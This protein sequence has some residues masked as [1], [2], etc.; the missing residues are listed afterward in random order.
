MMR[1][2][3]GIDVGGTFTDAVAFDQASG[4]LWTAKA[5]STPADQSEGFADA[6]LEV[7]KAAGGR[8][9]QVERIVHGTT[10]GTN[11]ILERKGARIG[12]L[13]TAGFEDTLYIGRQKRSEMYD[14]FIEPETPGFLAPRRRVHGIAGRLTPEGGELTPL[15]GAAV[16]AALDR[17]LADGIEALAVS[18]LFAYANPAHE[19]RTLELVRARCPELPVSLSHRIDPRFREYERLCVT[20]FDAYV[21]PVMERYIGRL[22]QRLAEMGVRPA[23]QVIHSRGGVTSAEAMLER[24]V[25]TV[26]SGLAA[27]VLGGRFAAQLAAPAAPLAG[28][29]LSAA[30]A[31]VGETGALRAGIVPGVQQHDAPLASPVNGITIDVGG[32][33]AD[34]ALFE[35][36]TPLVASE[37]RVGRYPLRLPMVDVETVGAGGGSIAFVDAGGSLRVG[38]RSAGADPGPAGYGRG[39]SEPTVTDASLVL[40]Y[41]GEGGFAGGRLRLDRSLAERAIH[42]R[43]AAPLGLSVEAAA[44]GIHRIING[45]M[46][47]ALRLV[48]IRRGHDP[49]RFALVALGGAGP[50]HAGRLA[51]ELGM[52][53]AIVPAA[54]G[55]LSALGLLVAEVDHQEW[56]TVKARLDGL[57]PA[58]LAAVLDRLDAACAAGMRR[59][60]V[61]AERVRVGRVAELRY[62]GQ[63][64]ELAVPIPDGPASPALLVALAAGF[65]AAHLR[66]YGQSDPAGAVELVSVRVQHSAAL[67][68]PTRLEPPA[69]DGAP[70][71]ERAVY[72][73]ERAGRVA[74]PVWARAALT[75]G[76]RLDGPAIV[77]QPDTTTVV[78][79]GQTLEVDAG[80]SLI[81]HTGA[82]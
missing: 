36:G 1:L 27:G 29:P 22:G 41:V 6:L 46:A 32:T 74:T 48:S 15:D 75:P 16:D 39:G 77:E 60:D 69:P 2:L 25:G 47:D 76:Q 65:H 13:T 61:P 55:V 40:G 31:S 12:I 71:T 35:S 82:G 34:V 17:L 5:R 80:G 20:A 63:S 72:L 26:L 49:R 66:L 33:S 11:A 58:R 57:A 28:E 9:E 23:L 43:V 62:V 70:P 79:P 67:A 10:V 21:R 73:E 50:V 38:P 8:P 68:G 44:A 56:G 64:Y 53:R 30:S 42:D 7:L 54:P 59:D 78:Y 37:G 52:S 19:E 14:L 18:Y 51:V 24:T 81:L 45:V 3:V 4:R